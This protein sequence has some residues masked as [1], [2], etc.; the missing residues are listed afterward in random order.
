MI[1]YETHEPYTAHTITNPVPLIM[2]DPDFH[3]KLRDGGALDDVS[4]TL[5]GMLGINPP[6][7]MSGHDLRSLKKEV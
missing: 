7:E 1:D 4:P 6:T 3:G 5:L 2:V